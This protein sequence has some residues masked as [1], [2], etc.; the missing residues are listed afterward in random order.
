M[1]KGAGGGVFPFRCCVFRPPM[2]AR[3]MVLHEAGSDP[4]TKAAKP[5]HVHFAVKS[6]GLDGQRLN[7]RKADLRGWRERFAHYL[8]V[9]GIDA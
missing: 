3:A 2:R 9:R 6:R 5:L 8:R 1:R 7:P 4:T